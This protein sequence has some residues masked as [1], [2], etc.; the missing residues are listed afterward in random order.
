MSED[1]IIKAR[2]P[3]GKWIMVE[4]G[5][6]ERL[7]SELYEKTGELYLD[8]ALDVA[9]SFFYNDKEF[10]MNVNFISKLIQ[11]EASG[12]IRP[13]LN[14]GDFYNIIIDKKKES[15]FVRPSSDYYFLKNNLRRS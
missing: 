7:L 11:L 1:N 13:I 10:M 14:F 15:L 12:K 2:M 8:T 5:E 6:V 9:R 4:K 3:D